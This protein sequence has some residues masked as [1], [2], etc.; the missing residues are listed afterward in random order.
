MAIQFNSMSKKKIYNTSFNFL[1]QDQNY[2]FCNHVLFQVPKCHKK[3][4]KLVFIK[5]R[6]TLNQ[7]QPFFNA[8][9]PPPLSNKNTTRASCTLKKKRFKVNACLQNESYKKQY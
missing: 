6:K 3:V 2:K 4:S 8:L 7:H 1:A 5:V 9:F